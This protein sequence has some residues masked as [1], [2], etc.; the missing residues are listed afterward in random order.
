MRHKRRSIGFVLAALL[1]GAGAQR[2]SAQVLTENRMELHGRVLALSPL[3]QEKL[4]DLGL[5]LRGTASAQDRA[6]AAARDAAA[7]PDARYVLAVY[8]LEIGRRRRD[9]ALRAPALDVLIAS[10]DTPGDRIAGYLGLRGDIAFRAHDYET[11]SAAW[12]RLAGLTPRNPQSLMNLAQV[13]Q[14]LNDPQGAADLVERAIGLLP[15]GAPPPPEGWYRQWISITYNARLG[16]KTAVAAQ[17][18]VAAYPSPA[19]WRFALSAWRQIEQPRDAAEIDLLRLMRTTGTFNQGDEY[20]RLAQL[21]NHAGRASE[22]KAVIEE[23]LSRNL[24]SRDEALTAAILREIDRA[25]PREAERLAA[26]Q[27]E[28]AAA[29]ASEMADILFGQR[30]F[31]DA[32]AAYRRALAQGVVDSAA[33]NTRLGMT[34]AAAGRRGEAETVLRGVAGEGPYPDMAKFWLAW[35]A[36]P[37]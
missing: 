1:V 37:A 18:L 6:L 27:R 25:V 15:P 20:Q 4:S 5:S 26:L 24:I 10:R 14:A 17:A 29:P 23:G 22:A 35:L 33:V 34:L 3:E 31:P 36:R 2:V 32:I 30:R 28:G 7:G 9:D 8:Q 19:N 21:L 16:G 11:A 12:T 13:R